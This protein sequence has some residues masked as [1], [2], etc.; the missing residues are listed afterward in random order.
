MTCSH[1][2]AKNFTHSTCFTNSFIYKPPDPSNY[3]Q[4]L[5]HNFLIQISLKTLGG[6]PFSLSPKNH[7]VIN[8]IRFINVISDPKVYI[9]NRQP[10]NCILLPPWYFA[11]TKIY[12]VVFLES[13]VSILIPVCCKIRSVIYPWI[14]SILSIILVMWFIPST[15]SLLSNYSFFSIKK[16]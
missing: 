4:L 14:S 2:Y 6:W 7:R 16:A 12:F 9:W 8:V 5:I 15:K 10:Y 3:F 13:T 11:R 1:E